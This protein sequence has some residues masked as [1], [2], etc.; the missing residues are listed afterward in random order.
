VKK[1]VRSSG[2]FFYLIYRKLGPYTTPVKLLNRQIRYCSD[3]P[4][5]QRKKHDERPAN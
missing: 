4:G 2:L 1:L 3:L 5:Q